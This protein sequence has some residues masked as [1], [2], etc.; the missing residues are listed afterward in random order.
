MQ[1]QTFSVTGI[2][3]GSCVSKIESGLTGSEGF[4]SVKVLRAPDRIEVNSKAG[5]NKESINKLFHKLDLSK[6][7]VLDFGSQVSVEAESSLFKQLYPLALV[8]SYIVLGVIAIA[9]A[10]SNFSPSTM[11]FHYMA[12]FFLVFSF[13]KF[14]NLEGFV[15]AFQTYDPLAKSWR[16]YGYLYAT[17]ELTAGVAYLITP[18]SLI[19]NLAVLVLLSVSSWGV[20]RAV[21][22]K[23]QIQCACLGTVFNLPMTKVTIVEN[24]TMMAMALLV[25][26]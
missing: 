16:P 20:F 17:F 6:Y 14:L 13:F 10:T 19:L 23:S 24:V 25:I 2:S 22:S 18:K 21:R 1:T 26:L 7:E 9:W 15:D 8:I 5:V 3:C 11:M 4:T 12:G